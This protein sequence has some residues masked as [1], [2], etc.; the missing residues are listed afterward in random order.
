VKPLQHV[1]ARILVTA[2]GLWLA[3]LALD[4]VRFEG[5]G[6]LFL[7]AVLLGIVNA[8]VRPL[9]V[10]LTFPFTLVTLGLF[11]FVVNGLMI[12]LVAWVMTS[13]HLDSF[14]TAVVAAII[15]GLTGWLAN[16]YI[17]DG[18]IRVWTPRKKP[19]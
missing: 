6:P 5:A 4:G 3:D 9:V 10:F 15:V 1:L 16:S 18:G 12:A 2:F 8:L 14:F 11:L 17:G 19:Q 7:A 13:F